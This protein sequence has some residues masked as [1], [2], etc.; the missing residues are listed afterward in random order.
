MGTKC[1]LFHAS[2]HFSQAVTVKL[3]LRRNFKFGKYSRLTVEVERLALH[4]SST[5]AHFGLQVYSVDAQ[6]KL[7]TVAQA[8]F[9]ENR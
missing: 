5:T 2:Q 1:E 8:E 7:K 4:C 3:R 9:L 6:G